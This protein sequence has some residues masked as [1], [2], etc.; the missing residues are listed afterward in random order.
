M[1]ETELAKR[2][3]YVFLYNTAR[4]ADRFEEQRP[5]KA[6]AQALQTAWFH[7][8]RRRGLK[9]YEIAERLGISTATAANLSKRLKENFLDGEGRGELERRIQFMLWAEPLS[10]ARIT[11]ILGDPSAKTVQ[12]VLDRLLSMNRIEVID[13]RTVRYT[14][15]RSSRLARDQIMARLD[16]L[17]QL[18]GAVT[19]AAW[20]RFFEPSSPAF[21]R[22]L[23]FRARPT[24]L[25]TLQTFYQEQIWPLLESI[26]AAAAGF[27]D[28][29][30]LEFVVTWSKYGL[31]DTKGE[32]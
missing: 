28:A 24:D 12:V 19:Q 16:G 29:I 3:L 25:E 31:F 11:Q 1:P 2:V 26:D 4:L 27:D 10:T 15:Q 23:Q 17:N 7:A 8:L 22:V 6:A 32:S 20:A 5:M 21:A 9:L 13:G 18:V 30:P 14:A